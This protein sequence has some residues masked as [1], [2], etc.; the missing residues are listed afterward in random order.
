MKYYITC[1]RSDRDGSLMFYAVRGE[2]R[3]YLFS[4]KFCGSVFDYY[5]NGVDVSRA[6]DYGRAHRNTA[7]ISVM[8]RMLPMIKYAEKYYS[9][10][11]LDRRCSAESGRRS[12]KKTA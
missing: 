3:C 1:T 12:Y 10:T 8:N 6:L 2:D 9:V 7:L 11:I 4:R 5:K